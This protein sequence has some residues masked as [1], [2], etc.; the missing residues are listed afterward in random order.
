M[1][2]DAVKAYRLASFLLVINALLLA[3]L[4]VLTPGPGF[5]V[6]PVG[7]ALLLARAFYQLKSNCSNGMALTEDLLRRMD[8]SPRAAEP[9]PR[10]GGD[11]PHRRDHAP[12]SVDR[13]PSGADGSP[14][15]GE[16]SPPRADR[17]PRGTG[18]SPQRAKGSPQGTGASPRA[19]SSPRTGA[20]RS[21]SG[22]DRRRIGASRLPAP[23]ERPAGGVAHLRAHGFHR[24][25]TPALLTS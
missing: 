2:P 13:S 9:L 19:G 18:R 5:P 8:G 3:L 23:G 25:H 10:A 6:V 20:D 12:V 7:I 1:S 14:R 4:A 22:A 15:R 17:S 24:L 16:G 21:Q 11:P